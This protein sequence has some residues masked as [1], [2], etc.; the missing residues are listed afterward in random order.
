[1]FRGILGGTLTAMTAFQL[2][3]SRVQ[4]EHSAVN[5]SLNKMKRTLEGSI[6]ESPKKRVVVQRTDNL[7]AAPDHW[8]N[9]IR[10]IARYLGDS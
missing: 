2:I 1:M 10:A 8:N 3:R 4:D 6:V 7:W 9:T 5:S